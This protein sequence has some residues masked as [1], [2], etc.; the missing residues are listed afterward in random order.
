MTFKHLML[1]VCL[2]ASIAANGSDLKPTEGYE[3]RLSL[4]PVGYQALLPYFEGEWKSR[5]DF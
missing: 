3:V 5:Q 1:C 2:I 4:S